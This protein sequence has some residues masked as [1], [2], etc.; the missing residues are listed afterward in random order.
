M[1]CLFIF[2]AC[3]EHQTTKKKKK[4]ITWYFFRRRWWRWIMNLYK[5]YVCPFY[6]TTYLIWGFALLVKSQHTQPSWILFCCRTSRGENLLHVATSTISVSTKTGQWFLLVYFH[7]RE[8]EDKDREKM[9]WSTHMN[10]SRMT[11][12]LLLYPFLVIFR[13]SSLKKVHRFKTNP[14]HIYFHVMQCT[15]RTLKKLV[16]CYRHT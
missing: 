13:C 1:L 11:F 7:L 5:K 2:L 14:Y 16:A 6:T 8:I 3:L 4:K 10:S 12:L 9:E 15:Q